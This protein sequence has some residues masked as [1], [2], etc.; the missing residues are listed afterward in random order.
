MQLPS[1]SRRT[2]SGFKVW[3]CRA[4]GAKDLGVYGI[5]GVEGFKVVGVRVKVSNL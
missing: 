2:D 4:Q 1:F 5:V 3:D